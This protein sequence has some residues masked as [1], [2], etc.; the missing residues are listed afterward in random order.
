MWTATYMPQATESPVQLLSFGDK[1]AHLFSLLVDPQSRLQ[2][3]EPFACPLQ[4]FKTAVPLCLPRCI[5]KPIDRLTQLQLSNCL[6]ITL[7]QRAH[8]PA[9]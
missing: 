3:S 2:Q 7:A 8:S 9:G 5:R 4:D 1:G 6:H